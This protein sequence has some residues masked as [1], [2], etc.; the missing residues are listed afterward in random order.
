MY[1]IRG[2]T[3]NSRYDT[4]KYFNFIIEYADLKTIQ[5]F[6][7]FKGPIDIFGFKGLFKLTAVNYFFV[8]NLRILKQNKEF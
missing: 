5:L 2:T 7:F 8:Q 1:M 4:K 6:F 3:Y